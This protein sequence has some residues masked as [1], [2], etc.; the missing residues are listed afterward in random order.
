AVIT[1]PT[2]GVAVLAAAFALV[3]C[4]PA[5]PGLAITGTV[6]DRLDAVVVPIVPVPTVNLD[7]GFS[8]RT[9]ATSPVTGR[10]DQLTGTT[11]T[12]LGLG[13]FVRVAKTL[14][15][16]GDQVRAGQVL[17]TVDD[18]Q[19]SAQLAVAKADAAV[20]A[21]QVGVLGSAIDKTRDKSADVADQLDQVGEA[22][23][24]LTSTRSKLLRTRTTVRRNL[25]QV[26][27]GLKQI[28]AAIAQLPPGAPVPPALLAQQ[29]QL[30]AA[31]KQLKAGLAQI[32]AALPK[33]RT[34]LAKARDGQ[35]KLNDAAATIS[36]ARGR[37]IDLKELARI[38]AKAAKVPVQLVEVQRGL[39]SVTAPADGT[40]VSIAAP[41]DELA[42]GATLAEVRADRPST[43]TAWLSPSE[44]AQACAG[45]AATITGDWMP[46]GTGVPATLT[47]IGTSADYPPTSVSTTEVHLTRA[48]PV[49]LTAA[50]QLP[51]GLPVEITINGCRPA[52]SQSSADR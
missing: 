41:G 28:D 27:A 10:T 8:T 32:D 51:A 26:R 52:A 49:E 44:L 36:D 25:A 17:A 14:V 5:A 2:A 45:D 20:A 11:A 7:A 3:G 21:A 33:L 15:A 6:E 35:T 16:T 43:V 38:A 24:Q 47:R 39:T 46:T 4:S 23:D 30:K 18:R 48:V 29:Q 50:E 34:G 42:P 12:Q 37:L 1:R 40:V 31:R 22:I 19:L 9:G 13:S